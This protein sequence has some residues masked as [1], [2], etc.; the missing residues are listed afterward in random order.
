VLTDA[1]KA[2]DLAAAQAAYAPSRAPWER[3]EPIAGLVEEI[4]G[5]VDSRVDDFAGIDDPE[6]SGWHRLE[7]LLFAQ[8]TTK[9]G[10]SSPTSSTRICRRCAPSSPPWSFRP[11]RSRSGRPSSSRRSPWQDHRRAGPLLHDRPVGHRGEPRRL[12]RG[13]AAARP[14]AG[15]E[16][17]ALLT[18]INAGLT[19]LD[20]TLAPLRSGD[21]WCCTACRTTSSGP[22]SARP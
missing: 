9:G 20:A 7:Y 3:I 12:P 8:N 2:D 4:D 10:C 1:V 14:G 19:A 5:A 17:P 21:G 22:R 11:P 18:W 13:R 6:F 16:E 15:A